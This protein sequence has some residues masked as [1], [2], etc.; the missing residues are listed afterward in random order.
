MFRQL[1]RGLRRQRPVY[2]ALAVGLLSTAVIAAGTALS[3]TFTDPTLACVGDGSAKVTFY[4][5]AVSTAAA[6]AATVTAR[7]DG[8]PSVSL[9]SI[10]SGSAAAGGGWT[11]AGRVKT[12][13]GEYTTNLANGEHSFE[14]CVTQHGSNGNLDKTSC[15]TQRLMV[16]CT[17][18]DPCAGKPVA[19]ALE[20]QLDL[21]GPG[22]YVYAVGDLGT[23]AEISI[24][25][26]D[27]QVIQR[28]PVVRGPSCGYYPFNWFPAGEPNS[29]EGTYT[30][31]V[32]GSNGIKTGM[33]VYLRCEA[34]ATP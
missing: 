23:W 32:V 33:G 24:T 20:G 1:L 9:P 6:D 2:V 4:Y 12:A 22:I 3:V 17:T 5:T 25:D 30:F 7:I 34:T 13:D 14:V 16:D 27:G 26:P 8:G 10:A 15:S 28:V 21:C 29:L 18:A 31:A 19:V 11:F